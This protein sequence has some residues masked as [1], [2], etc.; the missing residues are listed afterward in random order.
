MVSLKALEA[1]KLT[2]N[3][4]EAGRRSIRRVT[5]KSGFI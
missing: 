3:Q 1:G 5:K 2:F 4:I